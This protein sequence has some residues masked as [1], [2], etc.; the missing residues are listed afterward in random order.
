MV[1]LNEEFA[2]LI[3]AIVAE[4]PAGQ[5]ATYGQIARLAG[6]PQNAR[7]VGKVLSRAEYFGRYP[8]HRV[9]NAQG[10][11]APHWSAQPKLLLA[12]GVPFRSNG[13]VDL[14]K[15]QWSEDQ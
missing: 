3:L 1:R 12:E 13:R 4:I 6:Y 14:K 15:C 11:C 8:C 7:L 10:A 5:V 9:V 2:F